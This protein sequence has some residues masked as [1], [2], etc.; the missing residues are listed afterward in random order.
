VKKISFL[1]Y[2]LYERCT[3]DWLR[4]A[5]P[6]NTK[7]S[8]PYTCCEVSKIPSRLES[9]VDSV[10]RFPT[11]SPQYPSSLPELYLQCLP[12]RPPYTGR[13]FLTNAWPTLFSTVHC[14]LFLVLSV[15]NRVRSGFCRVHSGKDSKGVY[16]LTM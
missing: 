7:V 9:S 10:S 2:R 5:S 15:L 3:S 1:G 13:E 12:P 4:S 16:G 8:L 6:A 11:H 14:F